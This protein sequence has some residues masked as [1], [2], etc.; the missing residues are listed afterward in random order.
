MPPVLYLVEGVGRDAPNP[1]SMRSQANVTQPRGSSCCRVLELT[2]SE[3]MPF[4]AAPH[5]VTMWHRRRTAAPRRWTH[6]ASPEKRTDGAVGPAPPLLL[7]RSSGAGRCLA[8]ERLG[9]TTPAANP[10]SRPIKRR[11]AFWSAAHATTSSDHCGRA[12][13]DHGPRESGQDPSGMVRFVRRPI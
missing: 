3:R 10:Q 7:G 9:V 6:R 5:L 12:A 11:V 1:S 2:D 4:A 8:A 13:R